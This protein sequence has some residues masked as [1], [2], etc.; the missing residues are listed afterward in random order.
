MTD[1]AAISAESRLPRAP[2]AFKQ[3]LIRRVPSLVDH[4]IGLHCRAQILRL[5][6]SNYTRAMWSM[7]E[8]EKDKKL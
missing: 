5:V 3:V 7:P 4:K 8:S 2:Q 1:V 6:I